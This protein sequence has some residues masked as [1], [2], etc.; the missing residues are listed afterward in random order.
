MNIT[1]TFILKYDPT[2]SPDTMLVNLQKAWHGELKLIEPHIVKSNNIDALLVSFNK[3]R[4][5]LFKTLGRLKP[6]NL[7]QA[8]D[9]LQRDYEEVERNAK[10]QT[11]LIAEAFAKSEKELEELNFLII[12]DQ[13]RVKEE[14]DREDMRRM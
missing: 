1:K 9:Y 12:A 7:K 8:A 10:D 4:L 2:F 5:T 6:D 14:L 3:T 11:F 13:P